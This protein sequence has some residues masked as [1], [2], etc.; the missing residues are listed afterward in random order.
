MKK[1]LTVILCFLAAFALSACSDIKNPYVREYAAGEGNM[2]GDVDAKSFYDRD[3][4][5]EIGATADGYAVFKD[6]DAAREQAR[7]VSSFFDIYENSFE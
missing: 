4:R 2:K 1:L 3:V 6:P 5:F 7:F